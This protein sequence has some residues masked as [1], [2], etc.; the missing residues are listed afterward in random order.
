MVVVWDMTQWG[1][2]DTFLNTRPYGVI[3]NKTRIFRITVTQVS[4]KVGFLMRVSHL[5]DTNYYQNVS[6]LAVT[7]MSLRTHKASLVNTDNSK[8]LNYVL[9]TQISGETLKW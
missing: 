4:H 2:V 8:L 5:R 9:N 6:E 3:I 1:L 7:L